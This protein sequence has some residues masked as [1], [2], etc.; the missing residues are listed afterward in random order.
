[1]EEI[2]AEKDEKREPILRMRTEYR[3]S[4]DPLGIGNDF[5]A[6][7]PLLKAACRNF[8][9]LRDVVDLVFFVDQLID[10]ARFNVS[11]SRTPEQEA[12]R[13]VIAKFF[14]DADLIIEEL[15]PELPGIVEKR[16][17]LRKKLRSFFA[18]E[19]NGDAAVILRT[20]RRSILTEL[21]AVWEKKKVG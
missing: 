12:R 10:F 21:R 20:S 13:P 4:S 11:G 18:Y 6:R 7:I 17:S 3:E 9:H 2:V 15:L 5:E 8:L 14:A 16:R 1:M 19:A